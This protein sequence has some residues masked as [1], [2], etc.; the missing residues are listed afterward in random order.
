MQRLINACVL[1]SLL[2]S[3]LFAVMIF[4]SP[5]IDAQSSPNCLG[6]NRCEK[7]N[8]VSNSVITAQCVYLSC[9]QS[10]NT[11]Q[12]NVQRCR[13]IPSTCG[14]GSSWEDPSFQC[15]PNNQSAQ[16]R[17]N[18][19]STGEIVFI[20]VVGPGACG[21]APSPTPTPTPTP[22]RARLG[23][24]CSSP[25]DC[26]WDQVCNIESNECV[27]KL[28][29]TREECESAGHH[30][31]FTSNTCQESSPTPTPTPP[32]D[33]GGGGRDIGLC[34]VPHR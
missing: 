26:C 30:W 27:R 31:N 11:T 1:P 33:G 3:V 9:S 10:R 2:L 25:S 34:C 13:Q 20:S 23:D 19:A 29:A 8:N 22:C 24:F 15:A 21:A 7:W 18:C 28:I 32:P 12:C 16:T 5:S 17:Y 4:L 6:Q 14:A